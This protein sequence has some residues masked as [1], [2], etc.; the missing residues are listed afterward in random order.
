MIIVLGYS[1]S[2]YST[3][4][5]NITLLSSRFPLPLLFLI[6]PLWNVLSSWS[7][8]NPWYHHIYTTHLHTDGS[9]LILQKYNI[10]ILVAQLTTLLFRIPIYVSII[11]K[12]TNLSIS[13][14]CRYIHLN[15]SSLLW[16]IHSIPLF[17]N[18]CN[19]YSIF[20]MV[21]VSIHVSDPYRRKILN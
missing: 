9:S 19:N 7:S 20:N 2:Y 11:C 1:L 21:T 12:S 18:M 3:F 10:V 6:S 4:N 15:S 17:N 5:E 14:E 16:C 13:D 8:G